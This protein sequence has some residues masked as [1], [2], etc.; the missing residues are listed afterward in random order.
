[1]KRILAPLLIV[2]TLT[3]CQGIDQIDP[4]TLTPEEREAVEAL[5]WL[6]QADAA[7]DAAQA[8]QRGDKRLLAMA[9]RAP[10]MPGVPAESTSK[11]KSECGIRYLEGSTDA[12]LGDAHLKLLQAAQEY[13]SQYNK[14][15]LDACLN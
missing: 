3:G 2:M 11:A 9:T 4:S 5:A 6:K 15:M 10:N 13:A 8:I 12:V 7:R 14:L 1:V